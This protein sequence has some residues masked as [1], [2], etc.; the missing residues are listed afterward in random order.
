MNNYSVSIKSGT[1]ILLLLVL[2]GSSFSQ[3]STIERSPGVCGAGGGE[4]WIGE[5]YRWNPA[6]LGLKSNPIW[7]ISLPSFGTSF[8]N[9]C[10]SPAYIGETFVEGKQLSASDTDDLLSRIKTGQV[11]LNG[12]VVAYGLGYSYEAFSFN[13]SVFHALGSVSIP[14]EVFELIFKGWELDRHYSFKDV[15]M[16]AFTYW[17]TSFSFA[18]SLVP[19][20]FL[21]EISVGATFRYIRGSEYFGLGRTSGYLQVTADTVNTEGLIEFRDSGS[22]HGLGMDLGVAGWVNAIDAYAGLN[23]GNLVGG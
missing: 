13:P 19:P 20:Q 11:D 3:S 5:A 6:Y 21:G 15:D 9:N 1:V 12:Q 22:G 23:F 14:G 18:K 4:I 10:F 2:F 17:T 8:G 7:S 16:E